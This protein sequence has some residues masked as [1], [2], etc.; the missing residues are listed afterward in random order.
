[1]GII[2]LL[3]LKSLLGLNIVLKALQ[4]TKNYYNNET[5]IVI[6]NIIK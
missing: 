4:I 6:T 5:D 2:I 1:M 3:R